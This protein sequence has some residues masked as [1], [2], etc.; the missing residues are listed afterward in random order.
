MK[1]VNVLF[2]RFLLDGCIEV[3]LK[4]GEDFLYIIDNVLDIKMFIVIINGN[5]IGVFY[6]LFVRYFKLVIVY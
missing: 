2:L 6:D 4:L 3:I 1:N 5:I